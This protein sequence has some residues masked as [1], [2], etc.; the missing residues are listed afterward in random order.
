MDSDPLLIILISLLFSAFFSGTEIAFVSSNKLKIELDKKSGMLSARILSWFTESPSKF[1]TA[2]LVGNNIALVIYGISFAKLIEPT[3]YAWM[4]DNAM[5]VLLVQTIV[6]T[7]II[8]VTAEFLPKALFQRNPNRT[9]GILAIP[10]LIM[11]FIFYP[12]AYLTNNLATYILTKWF[13]VTMEKSK[14]VFGRVDLDQ[15]VKQATAEVERMDDL[16]NE[17]QIFQNALDFTNTKA[18]ECMVPRTDIVAVEENEEIGVLRDLFI[19]KGLSKILVYRE[20][21]DHI[22]GY[23]HSS[24]LF[25]KPKTIREILIPVPVIPES[26]PANDILGLL[27]KKKKSVALVLDEF[28]GTSG[29]VTVEDIL[30]EIVGEI[31]DEHDVDESVESKMDDGSYILS[32]RLEIDYLNDTYDLGLP[33]TDDYETLAGLIYHYSESIPDLNEEVEIEG[34]KI[35]ILQ[36]SDNKVETV[37]LSRLGA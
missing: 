15:F 26:M 14:L 23:V 36:A 22:I 1:I 30:E 18:R 12:I 2:M 28:G 20:D 37:K 4:A 11:Y 7:L 6:S 17:V 27:N 16:E 9:L 31:E 24:E 32:A 19:S 5:L 33:V 35:G 8:L 25:K 34:F 3:L 21:M 13:K 10:A 29:I